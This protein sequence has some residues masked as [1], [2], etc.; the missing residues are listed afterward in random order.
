[1]CRQA[2]EVMA[3]ST[4]DGCFVSR[5]TKLHPAFEQYDAEERSRQSAEQRSR[6][7]CWSL[8]SDSDADSDEED[9]RDE[10]AEAFERFMALN[11]ARQRA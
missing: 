2:S 6:S 1:M 9:D 5:A 3:F 11:V 10:E 8:S 7:V 4:A